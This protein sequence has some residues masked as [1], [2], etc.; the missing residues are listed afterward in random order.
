MGEYVKS[1]HHNHQMNMN[2]LIKSWTA[3]ERKEELTDFN[4]E[5]T[6]LE[7]MTGGVDGSGKQVHI[8]FFND[9]SGNS[10]GEI[11]LFFTSP[12]LFEIVDCTDKDNRLSY[13]T[14]PPSGSQRIWRIT[15]TSG[16][17]GR[18]LIL[19]CDNVPVVN[20]MLSDCPNSL[21]DR[22]SKEVTKMAF[23][24][25]EDTASLYYRS[26]I[27]SCTGLNSAWN[28]MFPVTST[29]PLTMGTVVTLGCN[30]GYQ[31]EGDNIVTCEENTEFIYFIEPNCVP[32][33]DGMYRSESMEDC[34]V[35]TD[36]KETN[37][38]KSECANYCNKFTINNA[39]IYPPDKKVRE[40]TEV[41]VE[42]LFPT[43][44]FLIAKCL[45]S[46]R[47]TELPD[48]NHFVIWKMIKKLVQTLV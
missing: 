17:K 11:K 23:H 34:E 25:Q 33:Q 29:F 7:L 39:F 1:G 22:W 41:T 42:C 16:N 44:V 26:F 21:K 48:C 46:G 12:P 40:N 8:M 30:A 38:E 2:G 31:L 4:L 35:C 10:A 24:E 5:S 19:H 45:S 9:N 18:Q 14:S 6:S 32:C 15:K 27:P 28:N 13:E 37:D 20:I 47:W 3:V 36:G 43:Q